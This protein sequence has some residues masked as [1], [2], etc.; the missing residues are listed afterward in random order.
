MVIDTWGSSDVASSLEPFQENNM[1][2]CPHQYMEFDDREDE[3][4]EEYDGSEDHKAKYATFEDFCKE[5]YGQD[6][7]DP[8]TK[9]YGYYT[10]PN[11]KW[12][13]YEVGGRW[14][15]M[16][17][18]KEEALN[19]VPSPNFS[20]GWSTEEKE[21]ASRKPVTDS[22]R[23]SDIDWEGM[24]NEGRE[25]AEA[26]WQKV[27]DYC[28]VDERG[29]VKQPQK[30]WKQCVEECGNDYNKARPLYNE[31]PEAIKFRECGAAGFMSNSAEY[32][33]TKE[34]FGRRGGQNALSTFAVLKD[35]EWIEQGSMGWWGMSSATD[36]DEATWRETF[37]DKFIKDL[38]E[39]ATITIVDC[40]I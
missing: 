27:A 28:G 26:Q 2:D 32:D 12:D 23:K 33:C 5:Y 24:M 31:Q 18:V 16:L 17:R 4:Q 10:N 13:W 3:W 8:E 30:S 21:E 35:G 34:E 36:E 39:D 19:S 9:R 20:W 40:H 1:G 37:F 38:P 29:H 25:N 6:E 15:G 11:A 7:R 14:A 22:A